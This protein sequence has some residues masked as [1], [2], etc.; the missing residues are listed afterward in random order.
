M[1]VAVRHECV[2][3]RA[4]RH[5]LRI[6][7]LSD[8][9]VWFGEGKLRRIEEALAPWEPD[10]LALTGDYADTPAGQRSTLAWIERLAGSYPLCWVAGNHDRWWGEAFIRKLN[11]VREAHPIDARDAWVAPSGGGRYRFTSWERVSAGGANVGS[12]PTIV[13]LHDPET[14]TAEN[15][16][17]SGDTVVL[18]GHLHGGQFTL[19]RDGEGRPQPAGICYKRLGDRSMVGAAPL[20]VS[21]GLGDTL[22]LRFR[23]PREIVMVDFFSARS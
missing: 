11:T 21:R 22:P 16:R 20:I 9:H 12:E 10:V 23:T 13:L 19:W 18:A 1:S 14:I 7:H 2:G 17:L 15:L 8:L 6:A 5:R 4:A 3:P